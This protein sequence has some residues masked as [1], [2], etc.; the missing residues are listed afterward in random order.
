MRPSSEYL[1]AFCVSIRAEHSG[2]FPV[3]KAEKGIKRAEGGEQNAAVLAF[4]K[5]LIKRLPDVRV[6]EGS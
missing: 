1:P 6:S 4:A 5:D 2:L 3:L